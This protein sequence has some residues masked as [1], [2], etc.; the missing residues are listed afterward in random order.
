MII[1]KKK[2]DDKYIM[3]F[4]IIKTGDRYQLRNQTT[5][6]LLKKKFRTRD[7]AAASSESYMKN[8]RKAK[9]KGKSKSDT[10]KKK[11]TY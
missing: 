10:S 4:T 7:A 11:S 5:G 8:K 9:D 6:R 1:I 3:P 2:L